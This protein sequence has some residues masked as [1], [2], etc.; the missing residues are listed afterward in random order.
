MYGK[1]HQYGLSNYIYSKSTNNIDTLRFAGV[2]D[3]HEIDLQ[4]NNCHKKQTKTV[5]N[6]SIWKSL[7]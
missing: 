7:L 2:F 1:T 6:H 3:L 5:L 4:T